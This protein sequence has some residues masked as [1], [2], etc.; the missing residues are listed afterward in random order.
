M[1]VKHLNS[2]IREYPKHRGIKTNIDINKK[3]RRKP[4]RGRPY[5]H[6]EKAYKSMRS[7]IERFSHS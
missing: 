7:T 5:R 4:K 3:N 2:E 6:N 1:F